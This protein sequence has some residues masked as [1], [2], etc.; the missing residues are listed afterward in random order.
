M[1][2]LI[3][4]QAA[5]RRRVVAGLVTAALGLVAA[6]CDM[7][8]VEPS[9]LDG[10][11][12][13]AA[14]TTPRSA[15]AGE[16]IVLEALVRGDDA[17]L[18]W[19]A[20]AAP[21]QATGAYGPDSD[22]DAL[23]CPTDALSLGVGNPLAVTLPEALDGVA[24]ARLDLEGAVPAV[25]EVGAWPEEAHPEVTGILAAGGAELP[26]AVGPGVELDLV[27]E[28]T[29]P[30]GEGL[31]ATWF[32][33]A[34]AVEPWRTTGAGGPVLEVPVD[35]DG[36]IEVLAVV[37]DGAGGVGWASATIAVEVSR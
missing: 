15:A 35:A 32:T 34:G 26:S 27:L 22:G 5:R 31:T 23:T 1:R 7:G 14:R 21:W 19:R 20:C 25:L 10:P 16:P 11:Q 6:A 9:L 18:T 12:I 29:D 37:R 36:A 3:R 4:E 8:V 24:W 28:A 33:T 13:L 2:D 17:T 30:L